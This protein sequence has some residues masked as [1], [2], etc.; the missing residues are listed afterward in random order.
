MMFSCPV[1]WKRFRCLSSSEIC[2][3]V[4][5]VVV[6]GLIIR[7]WSCLVQRTYGRLV[8]C[9]EGDEKTRPT[10]GS[11]GHCPFWQASRPNDHQ[12]SAGYF[13]ITQD[14]NVCLAKTYSS[15]VYI[16][17]IHMSGT[18]ANRFY[19]FRVQWFISRIPIIT[20]TKCD[21]IS[22]GSQYRRTWT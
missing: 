1:F 9:C 6:Y 14:R 16:S 20:N 8:V 11:F 15:Y 7:F 12:L 18:V 4:D 2:S 22:R 3:V 17:L 21:F 10:R 19:G 5:M 13:T